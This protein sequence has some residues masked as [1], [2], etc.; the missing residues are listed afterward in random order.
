MLLQILTPTSVAL[1]EEVDMVTAP[2][3]SGVVGIL[4][5][6]VPLF[7]KLVEGEIKITTGKEEKYLAIGGGFMEVTKDKVTVLVT[8]A[9]HADELNEK[10]ILRSQEEAKKALAHADKPE[11][12]AVAEAMLHQAIVD[13]NIFN[14]L[15]RRNPPGSSH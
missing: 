5:H 8:R 11:A 9:I 10:D 7:T 4:P 12:R 6:H 2:S 3:A 13:M 15:R 14:K 1:D